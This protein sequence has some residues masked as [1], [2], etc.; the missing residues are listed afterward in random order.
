MHASNK[1]SFSHQHI[2]PQNLRTPIAL[3][4]FVTMTVEGLGGATLSHKTS[5]RQC[6]RSPQG[7]GLVITGSELNGSAARAIFFYQCPHCACFWTV[8]SYEG[9]YQMAQTERKDSRK[10]SGVA[11]VDLGL[12]RLVGCIWDC[13]WQLCCTCPCFVHKL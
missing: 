13:S 9:Q 5:S 3:T 11:S 1:L 8:N 7:A 12:D 2:S 4:R 10:R 6:M